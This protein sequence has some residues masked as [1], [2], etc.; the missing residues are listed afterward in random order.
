M[1]QAEVSDLALE[2][3]NAVFD[4]EAVKEAVRV[5]HPVGPGLG[6]KVE[7]ETSGQGQG[8]QPRQRIG[9]IAGASAISVLPTEPSRGDD[10]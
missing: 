2:I 4:R 1:P 3:G 5:G 6:R 7:A 9:Q 10:R 8:A